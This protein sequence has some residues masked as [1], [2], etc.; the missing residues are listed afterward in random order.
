M[1]KRHT[2][3]AAYRPHIELGNT[4]QKAELSLYLSNRT[5]LSEGSVELVLKGLPDA[6]V[7][8]ARSGR[9]VRIDDLG[10][11]TPDINLDGSFVPLY[12]ADAELKDRLNARNFF[13]GTIQ[14]RENV[15]K[16]ADEL[17]A[18]WNRDHPDDPVE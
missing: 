12:Q 5:G 11:Y 6:I 7:F 8:F 15:G 3:I 13:S 16:T 9:P 18:M 17:V 14:H 10:T 4:V 1:A 2:A